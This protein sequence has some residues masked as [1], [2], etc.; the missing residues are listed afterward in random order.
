VT[1]CRGEILKVFAKGPCITAVLFGLLCLSI[2]GC[3]GGA[4]STTTPGPTPT[5]TP[6]PGPNPTPTPTPSPTP[7]PSS[8]SVALSWSPS[9]SSGVVSYNVYRSSASSGPFTKIGN[10]SATN[11]TDSSVQS[12][13]TYFYTVTAV[14]GANVESS[15]AAPVS[16]TVPSS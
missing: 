9:S 1:W 15:E 6:G 8:H 14:D 10:A 5:P 4:S 3:A 13:Q 12:G 7:A 2:A 16:A 11:F